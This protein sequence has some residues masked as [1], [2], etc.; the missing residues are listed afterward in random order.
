MFDLE[1]DTAKNQYETGQHAT[2]PGGNQQQDLDQ[3]LQRLKDLARR[4]QELAEQQHNSQQNFQQRWE[5]E[6]LRREAEQLRQ[7]MQQL[8]R[9]AQQNGQSSSQ[10]Q[11][12]RQQGERAQGSQQGQQGQQGQ[13]A[14]QG[15][16]GN[17]QGAVQEAM[18]SLQR[19]E[20]EMRKAVS[21]HDAGAQQR[22]AQQLAQAQKSIGDMLGQQAG[23]SVSD[24]ARKAQELAQNQKDLARRIKE[25]Y[26]AEGIDTARNLQTPGENGSGSS[27][28]EM[29]EM[30]GPGF[31]RYNWRRRAI[32]EDSG[33]PAT[34]EE[35][36]LATEN[37]KLG[38]QVQRLQ[39]E[40]QQQSQ[41]IR[42]QQP[43]AARK[44]NKALSDAEQEELALRMQ[45][46][47]EWMRR[48]FGAQTWPMEDSITAGM[49]QLNRQLQDAQQA[50]NGDKNGDGQRS[51]SKMAQ[52]LAQVRSLRQQLENGDQ[53]NASGNAT[54]AQGSQSS[55]NGRAD[56][57]GS[58]RQGSQSGSRPTLGGG[59]GNVQET[60][61]DLA[62]LRAQFGRTDRRLGGEVN[63]AI[64]RLQQMKGQEGLLD[65]RV[66]QDAVASLE[67]L[68]V[69]LNRR[70]SQD[71]G[72][73]RTATPELAPEQY[74]DAVAEYFKRLSK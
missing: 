23:N 70:V 44:L 65:Q 43:E 12:G 39:R 7:Q 6:Q 72:A 53:Q 51:D 27:G 18:R 17:S 8:A 60:I 61:S 19:A 15:S 48:G 30:V 59:S 68:E 32:P 64:G 35:K 4:Q 26:G 37:E 47:S 10:M 11:Q 29:P 73:A 55:K 58:A 9:N 45:K 57:A 31:G 25:Q 42:D 56:Q 49:E 16:S 54:D 46:N 41:G 74:R 34:G 24:L 3:A 1:L 40:M 5:E 14:R 20:D 36:A 63:D 28:I 62:A 71:D 22:A 21:E 66:N 2:P 50:L 69:E 38:Q 13:Q 52:A 67:K 33:R